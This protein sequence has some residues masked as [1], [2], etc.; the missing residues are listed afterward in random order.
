[1][2]A[3]SDMMDQMGKNKRGTY[4]RK[5]SSGLTREEKQQIADENE[6][7][8]REKKQHVFPNGRQSARTIEFVQNNDPRLKRK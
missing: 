6:R 2:Q 7:K 5:S 3:L 4:P 1:M 8:L